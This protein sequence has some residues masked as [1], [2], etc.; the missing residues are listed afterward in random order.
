MPLLWVAVVQFLTVVVAPLAFKLL[1]AIGIGFIAYAG[2]TAAV[3]QFQDYIFSNF[4]NMPTVMYSIITIAGFD[5]G[6]KMVMAAYVAK[7]ATTAATG[8]W[9]GPWNKDTV[10]PTG[11]GGGSLGA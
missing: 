8:K 1:K 6:I 4:N 2:A 3:N 7:V 11:G 5:V 10:I 9:T